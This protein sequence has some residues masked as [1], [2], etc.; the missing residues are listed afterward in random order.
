M[1]HTP[2]II[3]KVTFTSVRLWYHI[4][5]Q[6]CINLKKRLH[7]ILVLN[8]LIVMCCNSNISPVGFSSIQKNLE[9]LEAT[10][11]LPKERAKANAINKTQPRYKCYKHTYQQVNHNHRGAV[12]S[13]QMIW[14][15]NDK[16]V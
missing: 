7:N 10:V 14:V 16:K 1:K 11:C 8:N 6:K 12:H 4:C 3:I 13:L 15:K 9:L 2:S 5:I